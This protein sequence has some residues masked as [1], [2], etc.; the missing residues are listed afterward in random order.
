MNVY[1]IINVNICARM[2]DIIPDSFVFSSYQDAVDN[3][4]RRKAYFKEAGE[5]CEYRGTINSLVDI[6]HIIRYAHFKSEIKKTIF[7]IYILEV[8]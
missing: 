3:M 7:Y 6:E 5:E 2:N 8:K 4:E 1:Q